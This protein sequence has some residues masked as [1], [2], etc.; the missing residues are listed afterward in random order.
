[1]TMRDGMKI[2]VSKSVA[3]EATDWIPVC[4]QL[5]NDPGVRS[6]CMKFAVDYESHKIQEQEFLSA[7]A[8]TTGKTL[9]EISEVLN[10]QPEQKQEPVAQTLR[11][12]EYRTYLGEPFNSNLAKMTFV[13][14]RD[15]A[16]NYPFYIVIPQNVL[17]EPTSWRAPI[18]SNDSRWPEML[19]LLEPQTRR[20]AESKPEPVAPTT[21]S[22]PEVSTGSYNGM[23]ITLSHDANT[24][25]KVHEFC[26]KELGHKPGKMT[27]EQ[28]V[29]MELDAEICAW[30]KMGRPLTARVGLPAVMPLIHE[31]KWDTDKAIDLVLGRMSAKGIAYEPDSQIDFT[32]MVKND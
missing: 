30:N 6:V 12:Y 13:T 19:K 25:T 27:P 18:D 10:K 7:V 17:N 32:R 11:K 14:K 26:H 15:T 5:S 20:V 28:F 29:D 9:D 21:H 8:N 1:M 16:E 3:P 2:W 31:Y 22:G 4:E 23:D 24:T